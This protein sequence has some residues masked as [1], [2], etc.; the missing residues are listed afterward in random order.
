MSR[1]LAIVAD[2][3]TAALMLLGPVAAKVMLD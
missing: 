2:L 3:L 1:A